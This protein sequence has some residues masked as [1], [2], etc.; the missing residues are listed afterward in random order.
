MRTVTVHQNATPLR[1]TKTNN[2]NRAFPLL[3]SNLAQNTARLAFCE[4]TK[5]TRRK[6]IYECTHEGIRHDAREQGPDNG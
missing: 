3:G 2:V 1:V 6:T 4:R 5:F